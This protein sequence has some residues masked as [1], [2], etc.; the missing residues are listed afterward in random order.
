M[1]ETKTNGDLVRAMSNKELAA[2]RFPRGD[3][4][5]Q[6]YCRIY[7]LDAQRCRLTLDCRQCLEEWLEAPAGK[8]Q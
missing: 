7:W 6:G 5:Q 3:R 2:W 4:D 8:H 1:A